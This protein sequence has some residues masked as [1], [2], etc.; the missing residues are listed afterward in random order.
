MN[1]EIN[2]LKFMANKPKMK[3]YILYPVMI[4]FLLLS[5]NAFGQEQIRIMSYN[6]LNYPNVPRNDSI[7]VVDTTGRNPYFST[8]FSSVNPDIALLQEIEWGV[9]ATAFLSNVM[10]S[11]GENL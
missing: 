3:F 2:E 9:D 7:I 11:Y 8:I 4:T 5:F 6:I 10:I 1:L